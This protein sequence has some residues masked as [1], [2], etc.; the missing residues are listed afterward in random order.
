MS[1]VWMT[2]QVAAHQGTLHRIETRSGSYWCES[3]DLVPDAPQRIAALSDGT[4]V[5]AHWL[6]GRWYPGTIDGLEGPL[7]HVTFDD[8]DAMW[9]DAYQTVLL[10]VEPQPPEEGAFVV[11]KHWE[12]DFRPARVEEQ[13]GARYKVLFQDGEEG[14]LPG[15]DL[16]TFPPNPFQER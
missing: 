6:D 14:W 10:A 16:Y 13:D 7:R 5:W 4:R 9:L 11:A 12:G 2:G 1:T 3:D 15:D 8:G